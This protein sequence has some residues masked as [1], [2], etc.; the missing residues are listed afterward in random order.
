MAGETTIVRPAAPRVL[1]DRIALRG[2]IGGEVVERWA[3]DRAFGLGGGGGGWRCFGRRR[4]PGAD[5]EGERGGRD[6]GCSKGG[7]DEGSA[8]RGPLRRAGAR[9]RAATIRSLH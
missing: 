4:A 2:E 6:R 7:E 5:R 1:R 8:H 3:L 9:D